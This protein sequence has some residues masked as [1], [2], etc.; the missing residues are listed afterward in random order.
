MSYCKYFIGKFNEAVSPWNCCKNGSSID[1]TGKGMKPLL[2]ILDFLLKCFCWTAFSK[3]AIQADYKNEQLLA[4]VYE[5]VCLTTEMILH[6]LPF[7]SIFHYL[8]DH[9]VSSANKLL[10]NNLVCCCLLIKRQV[11]F[12][13]VL[14]LVRCFRTWCINNKNWIKYQAHTSQKQSF[15]MSLNNTLETNKPLKIW[16]QSSI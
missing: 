13:S 15:L 11:T 5:Y 2:S 7:I 9:I 12:F 16:L 6:S 14:Q 8:F 10:C 1:H 3:W 4:C